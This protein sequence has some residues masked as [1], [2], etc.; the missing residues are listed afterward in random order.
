MAISKVSDYTKDALLDGFLSG[1]N[2]D[3]NPYVKECYI[4]PT[5]LANG[6]ITMVA[7]R[8]YGSNGNGMIVRAFRGSTSAPGAS[9]SMVNSTILNGKNNGDIIPIVVTT[10][11]NGVAVGTTVG[12]IIFSDIAG[13]KA[14]GS[15]SG[16]GQM[17]A[18]GL[19][20]KLFTQY[21]IYDHF[22]KIPGNAL[23]DGAVT[24]QKIANGAVSLQKT[25][26]VSPYEGVY[27][28][29][30]DN[31]T[32]VVGDKIQIFFK[33]IVN[34]ADISAF[35]VIA[36]CSKGKSYPRYWEY[37]LVAGDAGNTTTITFR[38]RDNA[39]NTI[40]EK[41]ATISFVNKM[42]APGTNKNVLC[43]GASATANGVWVGELKRRLTENTGDGT[44]ANPTGLGLSNITF[45]G[46]KQGSVVN[47]PLE[48][49]GGWKVQTYASQGETAFR[50][51]VSGVTQLH[52]GD[53]YTSP[54]GGGVFV[55]QEINV[56]EGVG[57]LRFTFNSAVPTI[58]ASGTLTRTSGT[59]DSTIT[60]SSYEQESYSPFW[61]TDTDKLDFAKYA[62]DWCNGTIDVM[63]WH[64]G[65][66]DIFDGSS[67]SIT[68][69]VNAFKDILRQFHIDFPSGKVI[70]SSVPT[71]SQ[72]GGMAAN[73]GA[74]SYANTFT[75][76]NSARQ[77]A[78]ALSALCA[79]AEFSS[80]AFYAPVLEE[81]DAE[82]NYPS[83]DT[84]VNNRLTSV[85]EKV[86]TN[87]VH[88][89]NA[90]SLQVA[91]G[92]YRTFNTI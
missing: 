25:T 2:K 74:T 89:L 30:P 29:I 24:E 42:T 65:V 9:W 86:G 3:Y 87:G 56:T 61:N 88:P 8:V 54:N 15:D 70:I 41:S 37:T 44:P 69:A 55:L 51:Q 71:C 47:V 76:S 26:G 50:M 18:L 34:C 64:C 60:Y 77:Y 79:D 40:V 75:F 32:A 52:I 49:T 53:Q 92:V 10:A 27:I 68:S 72:N 21:N 17:F 33:S 83:T 20:T 67:A 45:V 5:Y 59:G 85:T 78:L 35:D 4:D 14:Q 6:V 63:I 11:G 62:N 31:I 57:N 58:P 23:P 43:I 82:N 90:G 19:C 46:R 39:L 80:F 84:P 16:N 73:Y 12:Y 36:V 48:A 66:N 1:S 13:F 28:S 22:K 7:L 91:D 38:V 81:F